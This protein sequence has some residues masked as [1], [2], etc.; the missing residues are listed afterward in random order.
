M[1]LGMTADTHGHG[2]RYSNYINM[3]QYDDTR[4]Y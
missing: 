4:M 1:D 3:S 2:R